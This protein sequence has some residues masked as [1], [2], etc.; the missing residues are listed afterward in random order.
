VLSQ[1]FVFSFWPVYVYFGLRA[2]LAAVR[3]PL[4]PRPEAAL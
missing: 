2:A 4:R 3:A 1:V